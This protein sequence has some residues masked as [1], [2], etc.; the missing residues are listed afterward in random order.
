[1]FLLINNGNLKVED[2]IVANKDESIVV[3]KIENVNSLVRKVLIETKEEY[4]VVSLVG[5]DYILRKDYVPEEI[6]F[7]NAYEVDII[8]NEKTKTKLK[9]KSKVNINKYLCE[10]IDLLS[11]KDTSFD[12]I[13]GKILITIFENNPKFLNGYLK[14]NIQ[15]ILD[16]FKLS[17]DESSS[18]IVFMN[19]FMDL[20]NKD[21]V[22][23][24]KKEFKNMLEEK[25]L[26]YSR[27]ND[28]ILKY[29]NEE[30]AEDDMPF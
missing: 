18:T 7:S 1:M 29:K 24:F 26:P 5:T 23:F 11:D 22:D 2:T 8:D 20:C 6:V 27:L 19:N 4:P 10:L 3:D 21:K 25:E 17:L 14:D 13:K 28:N 12:W 15:K 9:I 16:I 30:L